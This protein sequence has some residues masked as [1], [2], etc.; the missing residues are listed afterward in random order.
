MNS[1]QNSL[2]SNMNIK[3]QKSEVEVAQ[4]PESPPVVQAKP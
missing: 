1:Q 3:S 4:V 2:F